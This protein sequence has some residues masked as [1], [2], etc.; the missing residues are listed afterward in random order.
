[1]F[2]YGL[3]GDNHC[4]GEWSRHAALRKAWP[5]IKQTAP[6]LKFQG[7]RDIM[8]CHLANSY[9]SI[10][11][12]QDDLKLHEQCCESVKSHITLACP[13]MSIICQWIAQGYLSLYGWV[14]CIWHVQQSCPCDVWTRCQERVPGGP[15]QVPQ[16][17]WTRFRHFSKSCGKKY[18]CCQTENV[19]Y[20]SILVLQDSSNGLI[21][22]K[23]HKYVC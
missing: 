9:H 17:A 20:V 5:D 13:L 23:C 12:I 11:N 4:L 21:L 10:C 19:M 7:F 14:S 1:M 3:C 8:S 15:V 18:E 16:T 6:A 22:E 2:R